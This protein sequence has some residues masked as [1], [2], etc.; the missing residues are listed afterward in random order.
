VSRRIV[1]KTGTTSPD[2][3]VIIAG[4]LLAGF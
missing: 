3:P 2:V 4:P 1:R